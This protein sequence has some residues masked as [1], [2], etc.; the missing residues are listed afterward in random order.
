[1]TSL[2]LLINGN[3]YSL[4]AP[5]DIPLLW[6][7]RD[8]LNLLGTKYGCGI[9]VCG[10]CTV[11]VEGNPIQ[12]CLIKAQALQGKAITTIEGL[13]AAGDHPVQR[14]WND[15]DVPQ[16]GYCQAGQ[17]LTAAA[18]LQRNADPDDAAI[19]SAMSGV[20][21]RCGTYPRIRKAIKLAARYAAGK[22]NGEPGGAS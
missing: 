14:A 6:V 22:D 21:C 4:D 8:K 7:L 18:L 11:L 15:E 12:S 13:S 5:E 19:D 16:C 17:A 9:G 20:M 3:D 10:S 1:M 2:K